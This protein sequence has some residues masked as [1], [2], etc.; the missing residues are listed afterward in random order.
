MRLAHAPSPCVPHPPSRS[1]N[2]IPATAPLFTPYKLPGGIEL[3]HRIVYAP[4]TRCRAFNNIPQ[5]NAAT[6][7]TQRAT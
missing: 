5:P 2:A 6:Y 3:A 4:L 7:Y 1:K